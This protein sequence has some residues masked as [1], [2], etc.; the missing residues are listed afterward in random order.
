MIKSCGVD[1]LG[2][3]FYSTNNKNL[4]VSLRE[5][6][7][8]G[9]APDNGLFMP[10]SVPPLPR[11]LLKDLPKLTFT[12]MS[13]EIAK[14]LFQKD[15]PA[16][17]LKKMIDRALTFDAPLV[18]LTHDINVLELFHGPT[19]AFKD[20]AA[21]FMAQLMFYFA[22]KMNKELTVLVAT[23]GDTGSA[24]AHSFF[25]I[26][27]IKVIVLYPSKCVSQLQE[28]QLTT[29]GHN[30]TALEIQG[31]FDDCQRL[32]KSAFLDKDINHHLNL[33]SANSINIARL[34]PQSFYYFYAHSRLK[35]KNN[36]IVFSVPSGNFGNLT[37]GLLAKK[38]GLPIFKFIASTNINDTVPRYLKTGIF[39]PRPT[40]ATISN[41]MDVS[42]PS[43]FARILDLYNHRLPKIRQDIIGYRFNDKTTKKAIKEVYKKYNYTLD[44]HGAV[45]YLG[46]KRF[47]QSAPNQPIN[48][49]FLETAHPA[50]FKETVQASIKHKIKIPFRLKKYTKKHKHSVLLPNSF[51]ALKN[52]LCN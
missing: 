50:K 16:S 34:F 3:K 40:K 22:E 48:G 52:F 30:I 27:G 28:K 44:P 26:P 33:V 17:R 39:V 43:N 29:F 11:K 15:V 1:I 21:R 37:A 19:L 51:M 5:A 25:K 45:A 36:P 12:E 7:L 32:V 18:P 31:S 6:V 41:A 49:I 24:V 13:F 47:Q 9:L 42:R 8:T 14:I 20:F 38:M 4:R 2:M 35:N 10:V 23:S 46:L